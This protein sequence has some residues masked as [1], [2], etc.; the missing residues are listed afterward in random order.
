MNV[1][2]ESSDEPTENLARHWF[3]IA[4]DNLVGMWVASCNCGE[5]FGWHDTVESAGADFDVHLHAINPEYPH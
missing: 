5:D 3:E 4:W 1:P 2:A